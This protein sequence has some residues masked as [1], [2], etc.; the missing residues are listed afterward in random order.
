MKR[1]WYLALWVWIAILVITLYTF[2]KHGETV[3]TKHVSRI[4]AIP[5]G[6]R[7]EIPVDAQLV[8]LNIL[9]CNTNNATDRDV[10]YILMTNM[11]L[12][13]L[14]ELYRKDSPDVEI[15][16]VVDRT[17]MFSFVAFRKDKGTSK[18]KRFLF[19][20]SAFR[21]MSAVEG[22]ALGLSKEDLHRKT[23]VF[24]IV[25]EPEDVG[26]LIYIPTQLLP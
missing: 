12:V 17:D 11:P 21:G 16:W 6:A 26:G 5:L 8:G 20:F 22:Q 15:Q 2:P 13:Q 10:S 23:F 3:A 25:K 1:W 4:G 14:R 18:R 24:L 19:S 9:P 7:V